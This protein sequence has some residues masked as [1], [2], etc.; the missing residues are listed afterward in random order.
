VKTPAAT[1]PRR[2]QLSQHRH[3][4]S[5]HRHLLSQHRHL[6]S[7]HLGQ[8]PEPATE[9]PATEDP[10]GTEEEPP[11]TEAP[12][13]TE[14]PAAATEEPAA[15]TEEPAATEE[16][17]TTAAPGDNVTDEETETTPSPGSQSFVTEGS[18]TEEEGMSSTCQ[19]T[20]VEPAPRSTKVSFTYELK[21]DKGTNVNEVLA[22]VEESS[23]QALT[24]QLLKCDFSGSSR[25][26]LQTNVLYTSIS[27]LPKDVAFTPDD[28][29]CQD[30]AVDEDCY[31]GRGGVTVFYL[32]YEPES[33]IVDQVETVLRGD[34]LLSSVPGLRGVSY[35]SF[36][37]ETTDTETNGDETD[38]GGSD[39][40]P[41]S[42]KFVDDS[43]GPNKG[44]VAGG[45][46]V[47][48][49]AVCVIAAA[50]LLVRRIR[51]NEAD[52]GVQ[53]VVHDKNMLLDDESTNSSSE[54]LNA[55]FVNDD[56]DPDDSIYAGVDA[57]IEMSY[58]EQDYSHDPE[59]C[60]IPGC[61]FCQERF[62]SQK[63]VFVKTGN[64]MHVT[65]AD[66]SPSRITESDRTYNMSDT[67]NL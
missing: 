60:N 28:T 25:R 15:T 53:P 50:I 56:E 65:M 61:E 22:E 12:T 33:D 43:V 35:N 24:M 27:T 17:A 5:Q 37:G 2:H 13:P 54:G 46:V 52:S 32:P 7:Q 51:R 40:E 23:H 3:L 55:T 20:P 4:L 31:N 39:T 6:L 34:T 29:V 67:V 64:T 18:A 58:Y 63:P 11:P 14:E 47:A 19:V 42:S 38:G 8:P 16:E 36:S 57:P 66:L 10:E 21:V 59:S 48:V 49:V 41:N 44:A 30:V 62:L 26:Q 1:L 9:T 45:V